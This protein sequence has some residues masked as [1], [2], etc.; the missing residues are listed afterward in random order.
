[1]ALQRVDPDHRRQR[2]H[3]ARSADVYIVLLTNRGGWLVRHVPFQPPRTPSGTRTR[4]AQPRSA[5]PSTPSPLSPPPPPCHSGHAPRSP[6]PLLAPQPAP[7]AAAAAAPA[8]QAPPAPPALQ[9]AAVGPAPANMLPRRPSRLLGLIRPW[10]RAAAPP[11][12]SGWPPSNCR[13][14]PC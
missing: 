9:P 4:T 2:S 1:M 13:W 8:P 6:G 11:I 7:A 3:I 5:P 14:M 12:T 10:H